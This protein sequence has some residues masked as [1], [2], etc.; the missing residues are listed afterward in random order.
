MC[1]DRFIVIIIIIIISSKALSPAR[2][3]S[4]LFAAFI[5]NFK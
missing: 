3:F 4:A 2:S 5:I 1:P